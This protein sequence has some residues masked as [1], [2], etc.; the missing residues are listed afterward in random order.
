ME[1]EDTMLSVSE[2]GATEKLRGA[3]EVSGGGGSVLAGR[4]QPS[5]VLRQLGSRSVG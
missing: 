1:P 5:A 4:G 3:S 2:S